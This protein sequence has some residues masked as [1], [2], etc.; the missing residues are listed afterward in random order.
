MESYEQK[1]GQS[2]EE[3][4][5]ELLNHAQIEL[6][7]KYATEHNLDFETAARE[8]I[9]KYASK[10]R[11]ICNDS[12]CFKGIERTHEATMSQIESKLYKEEK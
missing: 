8:W 12:E 4:L 10:F 3:H 7:Q 5:I 1:P 2:P 11:D 9:M 6:M